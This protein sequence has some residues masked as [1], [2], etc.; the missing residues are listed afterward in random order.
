M[1]NPSF[2]EN[3]T[4]HTRVRFER[5]ATPPP[6]ST[7]DGY[8]VLRG[9]C[10]NWSDDD[11]DDDDVIDDVDMLSPTQLDIQVIIEALS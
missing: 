6:S 2:D 9:H 11:D 10:H 8:Q 1:E 7:V 5:N 4:E 3:Q